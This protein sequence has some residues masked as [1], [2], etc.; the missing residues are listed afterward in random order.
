MQGSFTGH[1]ASF[2]AVFDEVLEVLVSSS[3]AI[4]DKVI[5]RHGQRRKMRERGEML[6]E[7]STVPIPLFSFPFSSYEFAGN[8]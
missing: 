2:S 6:R 3:K 7:I 5:K 1:S 8:K 4:S